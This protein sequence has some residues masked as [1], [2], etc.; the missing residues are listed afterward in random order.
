MG[1]VQI[2]INNQNNP[3]L[4]PGYAGGRSMIKTT[5]DKYQHHAKSSDING[6]WRFSIMKDGSQ[7]QVENGIGHDFSGDY[8]Y[9]NTDKQELT[10]IRDMIN[11]VLKSM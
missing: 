1:T 4:L 11:E 5:K 6:K 10:A 8:A 3:D 9:I 7:L 2:I